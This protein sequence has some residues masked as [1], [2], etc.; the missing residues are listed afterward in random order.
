MSIFAFLIEFF[1]QICGFLARGLW[2]SRYSC[3]Q[4]DLSI[5]GCCVADCHV[6]DT[7]PRSILQ[8]YI[9]TPPPSGPKDSR[10]KKVYAFDC[11]MV[12]TAWGTILAR[13]SMVDVKNKL[14]L[15]LIIRPE[16]KI[17]DCN[18][19]FSGLTLEHFQEAQCNLQQVFLP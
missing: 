9:E 3:C 6:T 17:T 2:E 11:E 7:A 8:T 4:S 12:Y 10:S 14:V 15:D 16:H 19:R 13:I 18:T 5:T 1:C